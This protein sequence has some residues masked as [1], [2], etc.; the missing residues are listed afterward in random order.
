MTIYKYSF[1]SKFF[2]RFGNIPVTILLIL[3]LANFLFGILEHWYFIFFVIL[4]L[5]F[6]VLLNK[7]YIKTYKQFPFKITVN[8]ERMICEDFFF[9]KKIIEMNFAD[10]DKIGGGIFSGY[11]T[12]P[13]YIHASN[14]RT[15][16]FYLYAGNFRKLLTTI[17]TNIPE[18]LYSDLIERM[19][20]LHAPGEQ[21]KENVL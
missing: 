19:K 15:I 3:N 9:S 13:V 17:L 10:I 16:G 14:N 20:N 12:R 11:P 5:I 7:Y 8:N 2:Y 1:F 21:K 6:I 4:N 18:K